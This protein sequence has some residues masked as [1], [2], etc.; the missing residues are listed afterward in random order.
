MLPALLRLFLV[1]ATLHTQ[2]PCC[3]VF[4]ALGGGARA[5]HRCAMPGDDSCDGAA[6]RCGCCCP[7]SP[8]T[9][10]DRC[11]APAPNRAPGCPPT[12]PADCPCMFCSPGFV[13]LTDFGCLVQLA[14][15]TVAQLLPPTAPAHGQAGH[16]TL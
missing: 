10:H 1:F 4:G 15:T 7:H 8:P 13:P 16:R 3:L 14:D 9:D 12:C 6:D 11:P 5:P 2:T